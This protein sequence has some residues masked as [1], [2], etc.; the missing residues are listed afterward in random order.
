MPSSSTFLYFRAFQQHFPLFSC[1]PAALF[2]IFVPSSSTFLYFRAF[3]QHFS[4]FSCL[5][6]ALSFI[7]VPSSSTF[8]YFR[9]FQQHFSLF[10]CLPAALSFI[11]VPSSSTFLYFRAF[12]QH[13]SFPLDIA[14]T[15]FLPHNLSWLL[16]NH[17]SHS[18]GSVSNSIN[19]I[20]TGGFS[21]LKK[22][23]VDRPKRPFNRLQLGFN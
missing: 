11:F 23:S 12:Q 7:F 2:F 3:Q 13:I 8:L 18:L 4:L 15:Y 20:I 14:L 21:I 19:V 10:S 16:A 9:A 17:L 1:L 22:N 6:A 5:P